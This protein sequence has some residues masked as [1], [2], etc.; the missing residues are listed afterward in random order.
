MGLDDF[1]PQHTRPA[2]ISAQH[3]PPTRV[4]RHSIWQSQPK[5]DMVSDEPQQATAGRWRHFWNWRLH[6]LLR[7]EYDSERRRE[8]ITWVGI[9]TL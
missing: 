3:G 1:S 9:A 7:A 2:Q 8:S 4:A 5:A 6:G